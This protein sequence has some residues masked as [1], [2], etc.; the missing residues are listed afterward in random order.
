MTLPEYAL[1]AVTSLFVIV[2]PIGAVRRFW[3]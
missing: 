3:R 2:D 1:L